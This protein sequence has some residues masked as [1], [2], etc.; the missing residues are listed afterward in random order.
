MELDPRADVA[1]SRLIRSLPLQVPYR[2]AVRL[3]LLLNTNRTGHPLGLH[4]LLDGYARDP[5]H[6]DCVGCCSRQIDA[7]PLDERATVPDLDP[8]RAAIGLVVIR[9]PLAVGLPR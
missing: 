6:A 7:T 1:S 2:A 9:S 8:N 5:A 3:V 4:W